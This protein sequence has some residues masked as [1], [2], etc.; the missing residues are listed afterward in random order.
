[1]SKIY[2][3]SNGEGT[4]R[5]FNKRFMY[6]MRSTRSV[7][8]AK[9]IVDFTIGEKKLYGKM[10]QLY[11]P[12]FVKYE[13]RL[14]P[15]SNSSSD[16][17]LYAFNFVADLFNEMVN[18]FKRCAA[19]GQIDT[20]DPYLSNLKP[21]KAHIDPKIEYKNY[22][23]IFFQKLNERFTAGSVMVEDFDHFMEIFMDVASRAARTTP[24]TFTSYIKS[25]LNSIM[26]SGLAIE[27]SDEDYSNDE[28]KVN[29]FLKSKNWEFFV[30]AC[31]KYGFIIDYN[32]PWRIICDVKAEEIEPAISNYYNSVADVFNLGFSRTSIE[33]VLT[34][35]KLLLSLYNSVRKSSFKKQIIC[36]N[37]VKY[38]TI[39][40]PTYTVEEILV[41]KGLEYFIKIYMKLRIAEE[42]MNLTKDEEYFLIKDVLQYISLRDDVLAVEEYFERYLSLPFDKTYSYSYNMNVVYDLL[43]KKLQGGGETLSVGA[44]TRTVTGY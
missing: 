34:M 12:I 14:K 44:A 43:T 36:N 15:L 18:D 35:P 10:H 33:D 20:E 40:P 5:L 6:K 38:E 25:D 11:R 21:Y 39:N 41:E 27:I 9:N 7:S 32:V 24:I 22:Q 30:N 8:G 42:D 3:E 23:R 1:M 2:A 37:R 29:L 28:D 17:T 31:N 16:N 4:A 13:S 26:T 19:K